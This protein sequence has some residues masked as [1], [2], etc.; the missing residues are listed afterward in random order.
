MIENPYSVIAVFVA[1][2]EAVLGALTLAMGIAALRRPRGLADAAAAED[3]YHLLFLLALTLAGIGVAALPLLYLTLASYV[4]Q[5]PGVMCIQGVTRV[6]TGS[7][8]AAAWL[9]RLLWALA[10]LRPAAVFVAGAWIA[11]HVANR[12][13]RTAP[14]TRKVL[15]LLA[16]AGVLSLLAAAAELAYLLIPKVEHSLSSGCCTPPAQAAASSS[17][18]RPFLVVFGESA[19]RI[20][21]SALFFGGGLALLLAIAWW[22]RRGG[23]V[24]R[25]APLIALGLAAMAFLFVGAAFMTETASPVMLHLP[26]HHCAWCLLSSLPELAAGVALLVG[27]VFSVGWAAVVAWAGAREEARA[28]AAGQ[29]R[30]LLV[31]ASFGFTGS[32]LLAA[33]ELALA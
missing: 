19:E 12:R 9:P 24:P 31:L 1:C 18:F 7:A 4:P 26:H 5:W 27:G 3:R 6:G 21:V 32:L 8:G 28:G 15:A 29:V 17:E 22:L 33:I 16:T 13:T 11:L 10:L 25:R 14:L 23:S 20:G 30:A 2:V